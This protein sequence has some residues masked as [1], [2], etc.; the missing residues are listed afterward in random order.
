MPRNFRPITLTQKLK[1]EEWERLSQPRADACNL[2]IDRLVAEA[3]KKIS[4]EGHC[5]SQRYGRPWALWAALSQCGDK[6]LRIRY[7]DKETNY[8]AR[9]QTG[10]KVL[11]DRSLSRLLGSDWPRT[12][13][14]LEA[15]RRGSAT[16]MREPYSPRHR[17]EA[18]AVQ[19][20]VDLN[21]IS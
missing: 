8:C 18:G 11:A 10:G 21:S 16:D 2:W 12:L 17:P 19:I 3:Q 14:E 6:V 1:P 5:I 13:E 15:L 20:V 7:A 4:G 9:C